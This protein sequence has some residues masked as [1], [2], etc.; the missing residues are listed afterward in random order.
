MGLWKKR[1]AAC[2]RRHR[3]SRFAPARKRAHFHAV[4]S[5]LDGCKSSESP[6]GMHLS[7]RGYMRPRRINF[8]EE[9][10]KK[11]ISND[12]SASS[13]EPSDWHAID[14]RLVERNVR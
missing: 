10:M 7:L 6:E 12:G 9:S 4:Q 2:N 3:G 13:R 5:S 1:T 11:I 14:W 8:E